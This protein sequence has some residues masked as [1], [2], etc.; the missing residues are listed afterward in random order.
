MTKPL[1]PSTA[2]LH[3]LVDQCEAHARK[4]KTLAGRVRTL[5]RQRDQAHAR[6]AELRA[7]LAQYQRQLA[8][9]IAP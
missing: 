5:T 9:R 1:L 3:A 6:N 8:E 7:R 4:V 2:D